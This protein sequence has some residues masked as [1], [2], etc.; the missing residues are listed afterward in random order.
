MDDYLRRALTETG[1]IA[2]ILSLSNHLRQSSRL[3]RSAHRETPADLSPNIE[4]LN[5]IFKLSEIYLCPCKEAGLFL[6]LTLWYMTRKTREDHFDQWSFLSSSPNISLK[7]NNWIWRL[8]AMLTPPDTRN[9]KY[10]RLFCLSLS[11]IYTYHYNYELI[12]I[13]CDNFV[14]SIPYHFRW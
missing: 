2:S 10:F 14:V 4:Q 8:F 3:L 1:F 6:V 9:P 7:I 13:L 5:W 11:S 12:E